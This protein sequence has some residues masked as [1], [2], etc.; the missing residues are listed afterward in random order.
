MIGVWIDYDVY[1]LVE[2]SIV[3]NDEIIMM[4]MMELPSSSW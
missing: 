3:L 4:T 1:W 2:D